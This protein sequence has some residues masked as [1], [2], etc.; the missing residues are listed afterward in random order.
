M[1]K[2]KVVINIIL[3]DEK[4]RIKAHMIAV[5]QSGVTSAAVEQEKGQIE[6]VG[7]FDAVALV[8]ELRKKLGYADIVTVAD[9]V[10][11]KEENK[12]E[13]EEEK[14]EEEK[15]EKDDKSKPQISTTNGLYYYTYAVN[16]YDHGGGCTVF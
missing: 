6:V 2:Q 1:R 9:V 7:E 4:A 3:R 8:I 11:E 15:E 16:D 5:R 13:K 10:E 14:K 12:E